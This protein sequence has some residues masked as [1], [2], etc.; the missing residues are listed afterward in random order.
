MNSSAEVFK[1]ARLWEFETLQFDIL[2]T[3]NEKIKRTFRTK[4]FF[5]RTPA[6][7]LRRIFLRRPTTQKGPKKAF[8]HWRPMGAQSSGNPYVWQRT[9]P[10]RSERKP[11]QKRNTCPH[12]ANVFFWD[13]LPHKKCPKKAFTH[14]KGPK[15]AFGHW[16]PT[17][18]PSSAN[19][20]VC[21]EVIPERSEKKTWPEN[22]T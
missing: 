15:Q 2:N 1:N 3:K 12:T 17:G 4:E 9:L 7:T 11:D 22:G 21:P 16:R 18:A 8:G 6:P 5:S 10:E 13:V 19:P 20:Y 14:K